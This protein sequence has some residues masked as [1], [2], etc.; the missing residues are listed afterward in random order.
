MVS[1]YL[2]I[3][4]KRARSMYYCLLFGFL[5]PK[6]SHVMENYSLTKLA[7]LSIC[8]YTFKNSVGGLG[9]RGGKKPG[10]SMTR[11]LLLFSLQDLFQVIDH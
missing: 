4:K 11:F 8:L 2:T 1:K 5:S 3:G 6:G 7:I 10:G 9:G